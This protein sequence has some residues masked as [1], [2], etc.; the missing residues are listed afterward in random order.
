MTGMRTR[1]AG[2]SGAA[3]IPAAV[4]LAMAFALAAL[5]AVANPAKSQAVTTITVDRGD[6]RAVPD[7]ATCTSADDDCTLREAVVDANGVADGDAV[8]EFADDVDEVVLSVAGDNEDLGQTGDLD[9]RRRVTIDGG[10][11]ENRVVVGATDGSGDRT[12]FDDRIF[13]IFTPSGLNP[14]TDEG[15]GA[16]MDSLVIR[17]GVTNG[18]LTTTTTGDDL[19]GAGVFVDEWATLDLTNSIVRN[20]VA[21]I[22]GGGIYLADPIQ[23]KEVTNPGGEAAIANSQVIEN[24]AG[25]T[26]GSQGRP[27]G[28]G[29]G[30]LA[31]K[32]STLTVTDS[33]VSDN[34]S[35]NLSGGIATDG[36][37]T[38][39][40]TTISGNTAAGL[41]GGLGVGSLDGTEPDTEL[42]LE[43]SA[44]SG[45]TASSA[46]GIGIVD[47]PATVTNSTVSG[48]TANGIPRSQTDPSG[49]GGG[50]GVLGS[51]ADLDLDSVTV[52][53]NT[54]NAAGGGIATDN[55]ALSGSPSNTDAVTARNIIVADNTQT[56]GGQCFSVAAPSVAPVVSDGFNLEFPG[57]SCGF[58]N[59]ED[60]EL[61][62]L[63]D[64]GGPTQTHAIEEDSPAVDQG[65]TELATDQRGE[66][67]P[68]DFVSAENV[69]DGSDIG[70]FELQADGD[71]GC[72]IVGTSGDDNLDGTTG[73]D[74][75]CG[76]GGDDSIKGFGGNDTLDGGAGK[77]VLRGGAGKDL[78]LAKDGVRGND[79]ANGGPARDKCVSD[80]RDVMRSC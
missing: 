28:G 42:T 23:Q 45:N 65:D 34:I 6:D 76:L 68:V 80:A 36:V 72:T 22:A 5:L 62:D 47:A 69:G 24:E 30:I 64:N 48:N 15:S 31:S 43:D 49:L 50:I 9:I 70:A 51:E 58:E 21:S 37:A 16:T 73:R 56:Q 78:L 39:V 61:G 10:D 41:V 25:L 63:D 27:E 4:F 38:I 44:V 57:D 53:E 12:G 8:I 79:T 67:R 14:E 71:L 59:T 60:P 2:T 55:G 35:A 52:A 29:A 46:G 18:T 74:V 11:G 54:A 19:F 26:V 13:E 33:V 17:D 75:I 3:P 32:E 1:T 20:N 77:D 7:T 40:R 66:R